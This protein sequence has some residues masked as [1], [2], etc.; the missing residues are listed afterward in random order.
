MQTDQS[1]SLSAPSRS[2]ESKLLRL[3]GVRTFGFRKVT[4]SSERIAS[5]A[6]CIGWTLSLNRGEDTNRS[7]VAAGIDNHRDFCRR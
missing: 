4:G 7:K 2:A 6:L 5:L 3:D 1:R